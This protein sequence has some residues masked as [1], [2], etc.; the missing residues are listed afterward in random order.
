M[1]VLLKYMCYNI[2]SSIIHFYIDNGVDFNKPDAEIKEN[3]ENLTEKFSLD[4]VYEN[5]SQQVYTNGT[6]VTGLIRTPEVSIAASKVAVVPKVRLKLVDIQR[7]I[8]S[9]NAV[10]MDGRDIG[11]YVLPN[12]SVKVFLTASAEV[13]AQRRYVELLAKGHKDIT[14]DEVLKD[15]KFRDANDSSR[16]FAPL[17]QADDAVL[18]DTSDL[19]EDESE[20]ALI[21]IIKSKIGE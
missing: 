7:E 13:R 20:E 15:M 9:K 4:V 8:A 5:G 18:L 17:K 1:I 21:N 10:V 16:A 6:N 19:S 12:A 2:L 3:L 14:Y 11:S